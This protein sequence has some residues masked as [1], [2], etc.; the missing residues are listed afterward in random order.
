MNTDSIRNYKFPDHSRAV[1]K[2][3]ATKCEQPITTWGDFGHVWADLFLCNAKSILALG[4]DVAS[5]LFVSSLHKVG[6]F[7]PLP[8]APPVFANP[9]DNVEFIQN[10]IERALW[11]WDPAL[12]SEMLEGI[13]DGL[14]D[15]W[16][17]Y[18]V[19]GEW[20]MAY[21][22]ENGK[23][24]DYYKPTFLTIAESTADGSTF[25]TIGI[26]FRKLSAKEQ[27]LILD[28]IYRQ[29]KLPSLTLAGKKVYQNIRAFASLLQQGNK[30]YL[31]AFGSYQKK[32]EKGT[33]R[34][35]LPT[36]AAVPRVTEQK[37]AQPAI[38]MIAASTLPSA[39]GG[40]VG[41]S[42]SQPNKDLFFLKQALLDATNARNRQ[43]HTSAIRDDKALPLEA[44]NHPETLMACPPEASRKYFI[45]RL[46]MLRFFK[47]AFQK[48]STSE[49]PSFISL[50]ESLKN[51][52]TLR[53][54]GQGFAI[55]KDSE[56]VQLQEAILNPSE[57]NID[58]T[59]RTK[60]LALSE[61]A[62]TLHRNA[63]F[64]RTYET[65][66]KAF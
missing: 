31:E 29:D 66:R 5:Y 26:A 44:G 46:Y 8:P 39:P 22:L 42:Q 61:F 34:N 12:R 37:M 9:H 64:L 50:N 28:T 2:E 38:Q 63:N 51:G 41:S 16:N 21:S 15:K 20:A 62:D 47:E 43:L 19:I 45:A 4:Q 33:L 54:V 53:E 10:S 49:C 40:P 57:L 14:A 11:N 27:K 17:V 48:S 35:L 58:Q 59:L 24:K 52:K 32:K 3:K 36:A 56:F 65:L 60:L 23:N 7:I 55:M 30:N 25:Q 1:L 6:L 13:D 18:A